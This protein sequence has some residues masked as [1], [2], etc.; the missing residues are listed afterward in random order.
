MYYSTTKYTLGSTKVKGVG[1][2]GFRVSNVMLLRGL[3]KQD[4]FG[5]AD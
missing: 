5:R 4:S 1:V 3:P 2:Q